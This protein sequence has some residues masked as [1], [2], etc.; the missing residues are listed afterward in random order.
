LEDGREIKKEFQDLR[1]KHFACDLF[2]VA[3]C[4]DPVFSFQDLLLSF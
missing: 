1:G 3:C 2:Q 4:V